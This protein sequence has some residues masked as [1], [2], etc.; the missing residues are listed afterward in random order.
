MRTWEELHAHV[1]GIARARGWSCTRSWEELHKCCSQP[2]GLQATPLSCQHS[3]PMV[4]SQVLQD[5]LQPSYSKAAS[6]APASLG[7][8]PRTDH[9]GRACCMHKKTKHE[10]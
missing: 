6:A 1:G 8:P 9:Y 3:W 5:D 10:R 2:R 7:A 4:C